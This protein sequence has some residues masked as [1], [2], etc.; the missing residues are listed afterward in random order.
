MSRA[1]D[2]Y[3]PGG[4]ACDGEGDDDDGEGAVREKAV[5]PGMLDVWAAWSPMVGGM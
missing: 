1:L 2:A 3:W 5:G 4:L